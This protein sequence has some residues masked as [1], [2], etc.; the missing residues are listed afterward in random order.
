[1]V[2]SQA[3]NVAWQADRAKN[4][5]KKHSLKVC[6]PIIKIGVRGVKQKGRLALARMSQ[7]KKTL[8]EAMGTAAE[9]VASVVCGAIGVE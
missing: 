8:L 6:E 3:H 1:M 5:A 4:L 2:Q 9:V 7:K